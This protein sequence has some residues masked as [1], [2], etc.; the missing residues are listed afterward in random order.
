[1]LLQYCYDGSQNNH[2][3]LSLF[4]FTRQTK[5]LRLLCSLKWTTDKSSD[6]L[7]FGKGST[8]N[9][10]QLE[11]SSV[12][13]ELILCENLNP[14]T[15]IITSFPCVVGT[16]PWW[17]P[18]LLPILLQ[19]REYTLDSCFEPGLATTT[20]NNIISKQS[21]TGLNQL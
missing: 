15:I 6:I 14:H 18:R 20:V 2:K 12:P 9:S 4:N 7:E 1:M 11:T 3:L 10:A 21:T 5:R 16:T 8:I 17:W 13:E 19:P